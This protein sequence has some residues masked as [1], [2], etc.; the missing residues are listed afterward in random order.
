MNELLKDQLYRIDS[1]N[2]CLIQNKDD[3]IKQ[4]ES[5]REEALLMVKSRMLGNEVFYKDL[6]ALNIVIRILREEK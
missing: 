5:L 3:L 2:E 4:L 1:K 6:N